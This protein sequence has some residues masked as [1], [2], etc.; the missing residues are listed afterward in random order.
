MQA[1]QLR[2]IKL[3]CKHSVRRP[4]IEEASKELKNFF[5]KGH[6]LE[7]VSSNKLPKDSVCLLISPQF[8]RERNCGQIDL[9]FFHKNILYLLELKSSPSKINYIQKRRLENSATLLG[10]LFNCP[11]L[12]KVLKGLPN[13]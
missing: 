3:Q 10:E 7:R 12:I 2:S 13:A 5:E 6:H 9:S 1:I 11:V 4:S 8:L